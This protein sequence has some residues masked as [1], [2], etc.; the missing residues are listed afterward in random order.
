[1]DLQEAL[2]LVKAV[3]SGK[4]DA[5]LDRL[6]G[7]FEGIIELQN[8]HQKALSKGETLNKEDLVKTFDSMKGKIDLLQ[9]E[10]E[11]FC[12]KNGKSPE[13]MKAYFNN[14]NNFS[15]KAWE[16]IQNLNRKYGVNTSVSEPKIPRKR[17][18]SGRKRT[19]GWASV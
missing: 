1:M 19:K 9:S 17:V 16:T 18:K 4:L 10:Y 6:L 12:K 5:N 3:R 11:Q 2:K 8:E 13:E 15:P 7:Q 14:P